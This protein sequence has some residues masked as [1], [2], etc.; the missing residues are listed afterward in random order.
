[1]AGEHEATVESLRNEALSAEPKPVSAQRQ[2][3]N[4]SDR[5]FYRIAKDIT[6]TIVLLALL[7]MIDL[8]RGS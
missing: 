6:L 4:S 5:I 3:V 1:M 7:L 8:V 2:V